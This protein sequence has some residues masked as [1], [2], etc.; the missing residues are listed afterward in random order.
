MMLSSAYAWMR[1]LGSGPKIH[2]WGNE[3]HG[4]PCTWEMTLGAKNNSKMKK[5]QT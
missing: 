5:K 1:K 3:V 4:R 2:V